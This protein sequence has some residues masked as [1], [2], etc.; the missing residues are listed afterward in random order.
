LTTQSGDYLPSRLSDHPVRW[1][2]D[3]QTRK[4]LLA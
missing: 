2:L 3:L 1:P 4:Q